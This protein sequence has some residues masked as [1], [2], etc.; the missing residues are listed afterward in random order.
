MV[1]EIADD[2][3]ALENG[4]NMYDAQTGEE[5]MVFAPLM[6]VIGDNPR[7][8]LLA[9]H[10]ISARAQQYC[11]ICKVCSFEEINNRQ[12]NTIALTYKTYLFKATVTFR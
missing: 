2:L 7:S 6:C 12:F 11:R 9:S 4:M 8:S 1:N 3:R 10:L 5:V